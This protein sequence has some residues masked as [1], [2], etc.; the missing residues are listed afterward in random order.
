[1][2][3]DDM[4]RNVADVSLNVPYGHSTSGNPNDLTMLTN[5]KDQPPK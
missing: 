1:M 5:N 2:T 3:R 4:T